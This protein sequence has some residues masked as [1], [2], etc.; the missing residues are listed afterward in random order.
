MRSIAGCRAR[1]AATA[2]LL[3]GTG[4]AAG[5]SMPGAGAGT[6][7]APAAVV[8]R[9]WPAAKAERMRAQERMRRA[10]ASRPL[11]P[12]PAVPAGRPARKGRP[13]PLPQAGGGTITASGSQAGLTAGI[14]SL[15]AGGPFAPSEFSGTNLWNGPVGGRWEVIQAGGT[16]SGRAG[17][18]VYS[19]STDPASGEAPRIAGI[20]VPS[21][22]PHG[23]FTVRRASGDL[24]TLSVPGS[25]RA[26]R[27]NA[28][29]LR[30]SR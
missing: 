24:L 17:V 9:G 13:V 18:F 14:V 16:P 4:T 20:R 23:R 5:L 11:L 6:R 15:K 1:I 3:A 27:F 10:A 26:Y 30:F 21:S 22:G 8:P 28:V 12:P 29:S 25:S 19:R 7:S 2:I